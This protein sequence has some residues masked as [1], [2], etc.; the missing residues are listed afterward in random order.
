M[1]V[2]YSIIMNSVEKLI[3]ETLKRKKTAGLAE[4]HTHILYIHIS[5]RNQYHLIQRE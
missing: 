3:E 1:A 5:Y 4:L 2:N